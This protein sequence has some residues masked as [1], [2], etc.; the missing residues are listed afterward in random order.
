M[1]EKD[2]KE[3]NGKDQG[4]KASGYKAIHKD[5]LQGV[6]NKL[7]PIHLLFH[8][9]PIKKATANQCQSENK[10]Y[11]F[12]IIKKGNNIIHVYPINNRGE[13]V[14]SLGITAFC[15]LMT[16]IFLP[17]FIATYFFVYLLFI[18]KPSKFGVVVSSATF[19]PALNAIRIS[20]S[21]T[22]IVF[23]SVLLKDWQNVTSLEISLPVILSVMMILISV[24]VDNHQMQSA[25]YLTIRQFLK[26]DRTC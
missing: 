25:G 20:L 16:N 6:M 7:I 21:M 24:M 13:G 2:K 18:N 1:L 19:I 8:I 9:I 15:L 11:D 23:Q 22:I 4:N 12:N 26:G 14:I 10:K 17:V 3:N 5:I